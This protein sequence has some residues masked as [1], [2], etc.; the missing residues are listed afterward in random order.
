[1]SKTVGDTIALSG[2]VGTSVVA[3]TLQVRVEQPDGVVL[4]GEPVV[5]DP[6]AGTWHID[7]VGTV[8]Q[9]GWHQ[10]RVVVT[11]AGGIQQTFSED[12]DGL[13]EGFYAGRA[14]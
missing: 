3:A 8:T 12:F 5:D 7:D 1:M 10:V 6:G 4:F 2:S 9:I 13:P 14:A 11:F